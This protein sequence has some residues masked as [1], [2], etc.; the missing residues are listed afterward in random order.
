METKKTNA[1][2]EGAIMV[3]LA[4]VLSLFKL[5]KWPLGGSV[6]FLSMLPIIVFSIRNGIKRGLGVAFLY[7]VMQLVL[8][9][10]MDGLLGWGLTPAMLAGCIFLDYVLAFTVLGLAGAFRTKGLGGWIAGS[11]MVIVFRF[12]SHFFS[13]VVI[14]HS[15]GLVWEGLTI[16]NEWLYSLVYNGSYMLPE[17]VITLIAVVILFKTP[18]FRKLLTNN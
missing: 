2:V 1:L 5:G 16:N 7:S 13:G 15:A 10:T 18:Q 3:A 8:G 6:T 14:F 9:I 11:A 12:V 17:L 4:T